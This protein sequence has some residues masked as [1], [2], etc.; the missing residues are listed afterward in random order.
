SWEVA[1]GGGG[2]NVALKTAFPL[3]HSAPTNGQAAPAPG[4]G[5]MGA[6]AHFP[7][8][9]VHGKAVIAYG[10]PNPGGH[11]DPALTWGVV[12]RAEAEGA[13]ALFIVLGFPGNVINEPTAAGT[14]DPA[15]I[16]VFMLGNQDGTVIRQ[17]LEQYHSPRFCFGFT[18]DRRA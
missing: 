15:R 1:V 9:G 2:K 13:A 16:P 7:G 3:Y 6:P 18:A 12:R 8:R 5:G 10:F 11:E 14:T 4:W 17:M